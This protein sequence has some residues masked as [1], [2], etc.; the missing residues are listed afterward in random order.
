MKRFVSSV[1][2]G[3]LLC[4]ALPIASVQAAQGHSDSKVSDWSPGVTVRSSEGSQAKV[5]SLP[6]KTVVTQM[7]GRH[8]IRIDGHHKVVIKT[9]AGTVVANDG[10]FLVDCQDRTKLHVFSGDAGLVAP[11]ANA[12]VPFMLKGFAKPTQV[13]L[14]GGD[15]RARNR[16]D[17]EFR[18]GTNR[19]KAI[20]RIKPPKPI[21]KPII[22][23]TPPVQPPP[24]VNVPPVTPRVTPPV[25][26]T[27]P[28][29]PPVN[30]PA[31]VGGGGQWWPWALGGLAL[32]G[33]IFALIDGNRN[34]DP[35]P[36]A[37]P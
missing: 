20:N 34:N 19:N 24:T 26:N 14:D 21:S 7:S 23:V 3:S 4:A 18:K 22:R 17:D 27:P 8:H 30:P 6:E 31:A 12:E 15:I 5:E 35:I 1:L 36:P 32:G 13:A 10:E 29:T 37:S 11:T 2:A 25:V 28:V 33:G 16:D 9:A